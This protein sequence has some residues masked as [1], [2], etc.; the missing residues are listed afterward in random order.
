MH[1]GSSPNISRCAAAGCYS[2]ALCVSLTWRRCN[3]IPATWLIPCGAI[4]TIIG[5]LCC[6]SKKGWN[7]FYR[8]CLVFLSRKNYFAIIILNVL[9]PSP[10]FWGWWHI[11]WTTYFLVPN[12]VGIMS[13]KSSPGGQSFNFNTMNWPSLSCSRS[14]FAK[15]QHTLVTWLTSE[16]N[17]RETVTGRSSQTK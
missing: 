2:Y 8:P 4:L 12:L 6:L 17:G 7:E 13:L 15:K 9:S 11:I 3:S 14:T 16:R 5:C 10:T 1:G